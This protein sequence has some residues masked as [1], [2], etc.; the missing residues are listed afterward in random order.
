MQCSGD[1]VPL[2]V[3]TQKLETSRS[4]FTAFF[5]TGIDALAAKAVQFD[6]LAQLHRDK[7]SANRWTACLCKGQNVKTCVLSSRIKG[8]ML[9][10]HIH[11]GLSTKR[12]AHCW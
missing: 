5:F 9:T 7:A 1:E 3:E 12:I 2:T 11:G 6:Y 10:H 8:S 4:G